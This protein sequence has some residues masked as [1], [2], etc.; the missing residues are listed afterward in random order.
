MKYILLFAVSRFSV[1]DGAQKNISG[2][3][4]DLNGVL[5]GAAVVEKECLRMV[6]LQMLTAV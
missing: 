6:L 5:P 4:K 3:V 2:T 1:F